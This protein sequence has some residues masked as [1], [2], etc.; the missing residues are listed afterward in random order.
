MRPV[1]TGGGFWVIGVSV[2][3]AMLFA[4]DYLGNKN[5]FGKFLT[6]ASNL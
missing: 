5:F 2:F 6:L 4:P 1:R 3:S